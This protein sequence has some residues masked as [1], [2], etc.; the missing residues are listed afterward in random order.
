MLRKLLLAAVL[1]G[2]W[3][4][5]VQPVVLE[6]WTYMAALL[7]AREHGRLLLVVNRRGAAECGDLCVG[8]GCGECHDGAQP[9]TLPEAL[10]GGLPLRGHYVVYLG[11]GTFNWLPCLADYLRHL[12]GVPV[13]TL[14]P[15][16]L[17]ELMAP[18]CPAIPNLIWWRQSQQHLYGM[19]NPVAKWAWAW[20]RG[21][22]TTDPWNCKVSASKWTC[23]SSPSN[24]TWWHPEAKM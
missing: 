15:S 6:R 1:A 3:D 7:R 10:G 8:S 16:S 23:P 19:S 18:L 20:R 14:P 13:Y 11:A 12:E 5:W 24:T 22:T 17:G 2:W 21:N 4:L 9:L